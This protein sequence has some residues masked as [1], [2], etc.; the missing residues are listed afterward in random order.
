MGKVLGTSATGSTR[1]SADL[2]RWAIFAVWKDDTAY[3]GFLQSSTLMNRW[4]A[5]ANTLEQFV[6]KPISSRGT[7]GGV[8]PF[9]TASAADEGV[10][11]IAILT[12]ASVRLTKFWKF[13]RAV[14]R[15]DDALRRQSG[16]SLA[17]GIGEWPIGQQATF[18]VW[19][20]LDAMASF[21]H[22]GTEHSDVIRR[23][24]AENWYSEEM[25]SRFAVLRRAS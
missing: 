11:E 23:T 12:R 14:P 13:A 24:Y 9:E 6:L 4:R 17:L 1:I 7:W 20:S 18:S 10:G 25:F 5:S 3:E 8:D 19:D 2:S 16:C 22:T 15:V 21:A